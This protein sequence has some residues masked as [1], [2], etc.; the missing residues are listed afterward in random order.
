METHLQQVL[1]MSG[2]TSYTFAGIKSSVKGTIIPKLNVT[3]ATKLIG[4]FANSRINA[5]LKD[6]K[7]QKTKDF[8]DMFNGNTS[9]NT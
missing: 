3:D 6:W 9:F 8:S 1:S 2:D 4:T 5:P 7:V